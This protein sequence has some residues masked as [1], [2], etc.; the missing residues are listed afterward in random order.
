MTPTLDLDLLRA[1]VAVAQAES[2]TRAAAQLGRSQPALSL[3]I[4]KLEAALERRLFDRSKAGVT[5]TA[6]GLDF[7]PHATRLLAHNDEVVAQLRETFVAGDVRFG[8]PEDIATTHLSSIIARFAEAHPRIRLSVTCDFTSNLLALLSQ[9]RLDLALVKREPQPGAD[10]DRLYTEPLRWA[11]RDIG[12][13]AQDP[14]P[15]V[16]AP[17]PDIYRRRALAALREAGRSFREVFVSPSFAG[18]LAALHA[19]LGVAVMPLTFAPPSLRLDDPSLPPLGAI[20]I[21][22][23]HAKGQRTGPAELLSRDIRQLMKQDKRPA[24]RLGWSDDLTTSATSPV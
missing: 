2:L 16:L 18:Q 10:P 20:D 21:A 11:G 4:Q 9:G 14:V 12:M 19:G 17:E 15:L 8:A 23:V 22:L 13:L 3:Q 7:L 5:L 6:Q 1:F 24:G